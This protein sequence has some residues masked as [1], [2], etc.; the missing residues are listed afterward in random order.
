MQVINWSPLPSWEL[1]AHIDLKDEEVGWSSSLSLVST[2]SSFKSQKV[3]ITWIYRPMLR[4]QTCV[5]CWDVIPS[6]Q[7]GSD[8]KFASHIHCH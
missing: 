4:Q 7:F 3:T 5:D 6:A 8:V 2:I 1:L